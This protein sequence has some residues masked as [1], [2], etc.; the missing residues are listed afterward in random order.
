MAKVVVVGGSFAGLTAALDLR[1]GLGKEHDVVLISNNPDFVFIPSLPW[2]VLGSRTA[3]DVSFPLAPTLAKQGIEFLN[4]AITKI[5]PDNNIVHTKDK[6][7]NYDYLVLGTGP[8]LDFE[9]IEGLGPHNGY[10]QSICN[11]PHA[12][13]AQVKF[14]EF[15]K[16]PGPVVVG[17]AQGGSCFGAGYEFVLN[18]DT[19]LRKH[20]IRDKVP[21]TWVTSEPFLGHF[22]LGGVGDSEKMVTKLFEERGIKTYP[23]HAISKIEQNQVVLDDG[24]ELPFNYSMIIPAFKGID[25]ILQ[26][27]GIGNARGFVPVNNE[28][29]HPDYHNIFAAGVIVAMSPKTPTP[30]PTGVPKTGYMSEHMAKAVARNII[31]DLGKMPNSE[32]DPYNMDALCMLDMGD[33][34]VY[35]VVDPIFPPQRSYTLKYGPWVHAGK[36]AFEKYFIWKMKNGLTNLP[37]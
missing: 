21:V 11:L 1:R 13:M 18:V 35:M 19:Y 17:V 25:A 16:N 34:G 12:M 32:F 8:S 20:G 23:N 10:T 7:I 29:R 6:A 4:E 31:A 37:I 15:M 33:S 36:I 2:V 28:M 22:G 9:A 24:T 30:V 26:S 5:E 14:E 27:P 3:K